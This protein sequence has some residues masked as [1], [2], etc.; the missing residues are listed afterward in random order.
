VG[1]GLSDLP[2]R[3]CQCRHPQPSSRE[4]RRARRQP[5]Q[6]CHRPQGF[7]RS[8]RVSHSA[9]SSDSSDLPMRH[10]RRLVR[11][12]DHPG[13]KPVNTGYATSLCN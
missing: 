2:F 11:G 4:P 6:G 10:I 3:P 1:I 7:R 13:V 9:T 8:C 5:G 12:P